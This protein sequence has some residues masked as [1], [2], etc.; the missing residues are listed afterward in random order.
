MQFARSNTLSYIYSSSVA[1]KDAMSNAM[2]HTLFFA[3]NAG[4]LVAAVMLVL[5]IVNFMLAFHSEHAAVRQK[6]KDDTWLLARCGEP[7]FYLKLKQHSDLCAEV[8]ANARRSVLLHCVKTALKQT[9]LCGFV[10]C[11]ELA[12]N[13]VQTILR[14]G[15]FTVAITLAILLLVPLIFVSLWRS[16]VH[17]LA[18]NHLKQ[19]YN[20]PY[21]F[22]AA[23][24]HSEREAAS[25]RRR[26]TIRYENLVDPVSMPI[27]V[28]VYANGV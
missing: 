5:V 16:I 4:L 12:N 7:D 24:L 27:S 28:P 23:L 26:P 25:L 20:M 15:L 2:Q 22:N 13:I 9:E 14:G 6:L 21:G 10:S 8:E 3:K 1:C 11:A 17:S 19:Q 18:E